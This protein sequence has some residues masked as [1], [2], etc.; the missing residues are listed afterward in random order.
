MKKIKLKFLSMI[1]I[2]AMI[3]T[4]FTGLSG[5]VSASAA[6]GANIYVTICDG[7]KNMVVRQQSVTVTDVDSDGALTIYD[8]LYC[9][10]EK[11]YKG[12]AE[13]GF[14]A[15][16][17]E[18]YDGLSLKKLWGV[19]NGGSYGYYLNDM[20]AWSLLDPVAEGDYLNAFIYSDTT[21]FSDSYAFFD[22]R[23]YG[24]NKNKKIKVTLYSYSYDENWNPVKTPVANAMIYINGVESGLVTDENG[25]VKGVLP[26]VSGSYLISAASAEANLVPPSALVFIKPSYDEEITVNGLK[27]TVIKKGSFLGKMGKVTLSKATVGNK[28]IPKK[29]E[30]AGIT[31]KVKVVD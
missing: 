4:G 29:I 24:C 7:T 8:A 31:Y 1:L 26:P 11:Y 15:E 14:A 28:K 17:I 9:A 23:V 18:G 6:D 2:A 13:A 5:S 22:A 10:H 16:S 20:S 30:Y 25:T 12:G 19:E 27:Y 21:Y 3:V